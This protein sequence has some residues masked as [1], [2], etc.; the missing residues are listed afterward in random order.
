MSFISQFAEYTYSSDIY[1]SYS[2]SPSAEL[3]AGAVALFVLLGLV[4]FVIAYVIMALLLGRIFKKAGIASWI[5]WVPFYGT[6]K[7]LELGGQQGFWAV[8]AI[9][10]IVNYVAIVFLYIAMYR[11]GLK[12]G[13]ESWFVL[14]AI[15]VPI[16]W[17][18]WLALDNSKWSVKISKD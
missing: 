16:V 17:Y 10:P 15:F 7:M 18:A 9:V 8:L 2:T 13:K 12:F 4:F 6:W 1:S 5:A 3:S 14:L 11:I